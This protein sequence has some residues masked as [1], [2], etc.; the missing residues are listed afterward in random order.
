M[1]RIAA[2]HRMIF[3]FPEAARKCHMLRARDLLVAQEQHAVL[4]QC[5]P[6]L[7]K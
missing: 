4:K 3:Q 5:R 6:D 2:R 1:F 7:A